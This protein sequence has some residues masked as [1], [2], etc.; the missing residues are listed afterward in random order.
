[1]KLCKVKESFLFTNKCLLI[2]KDC[3]NTNIY[4]LNGKKEYFLIK[5]NEIIYHRQLPYELHIKT[6]TNLNIEIFLPKYYLVENKDYNEDYEYYLDLLNVP[7][8]KQKTKFK[9]VP[10]LTLKIIRKLVDILIVISYKDFVKL[11]KF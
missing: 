8:L 11:L 5:N 1:M 10:F 9:E 2:G 4:E 3:Y 7:I 6:Y